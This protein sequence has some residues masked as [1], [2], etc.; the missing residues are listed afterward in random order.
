MRTLLFYISGHG[1]GHVVRMSLV[2]RELRRMHP[3]W[4]ILARTQAPCEMLPD[5]VECSSAEIDAGVVEREAGI[6]VDEEATV[7]RLKG[8]LRRWDEIVAEETAFV[9]QNEVDL[10]VADVP[11]IAGDIAYAAGVS[12]VAISNFTWDWIYEPYARGHLARLEA[13]YS[14]MHV[15]L[16]LPFAQTDRLRRF[17]EDRRRAVDRA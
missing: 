4:R 5:G 12:C 2:M 14:R 10:I 16:R 15:L 17:P 11:P 8:L 6:V 3:G 1:Y 9:R 7:E 13:A